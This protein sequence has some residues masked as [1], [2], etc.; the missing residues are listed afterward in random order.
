MIRDY[1]QASNDL[2]KL[3]SLLEKQPKDNDNQDGALER[4]ISNN[5]DLSQARLRLSTVEEESRKEIPL[6]MYMILWVFRQLQFVLSKLNY[7]GLQKAIFLFYEGVLY[8]FSFNFNYRCEF[9]TM[10]TFKILTLG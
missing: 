6:D 2:H 7:I 9:S 1:G 8:Y 4:S 5:G 10:F 3:I